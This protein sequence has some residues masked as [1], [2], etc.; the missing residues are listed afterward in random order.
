MLSIWDG[1]LVC[2]GLPLWVQVQFHYR[3]GWRVWM[4]SRFPTLMLW[5]WGLEGAESQCL[6]EIMESLFGNLGRPGA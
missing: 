4:T 6:R 1:V 2:S 5:G 3:M